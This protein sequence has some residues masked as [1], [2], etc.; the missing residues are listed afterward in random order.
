[1][2]LLARFRKVTTFQARK[3]INKLISQKIVKSFNLKNIYKAN[4]T[5][6]RGIKNRMSTSIYKM[7]ALTW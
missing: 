2:N 3:V 6:T 5:R 1:M 4:K 7:N